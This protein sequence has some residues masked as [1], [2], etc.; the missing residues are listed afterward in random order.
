M[1]RLRRYFEACM[2]EQTMRDVTILV[3]L[4]RTSAGPAWWAESP[5]VPGLS[6]LEDELVKL[7]PQTKA[8]IAEL[9]AERGETLGHAR[10]YLVPADSR[11]AP[12]APSVTSTD[13]PLPAASPGRELVAA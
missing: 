3:H 1:N 4:E 10:A 7:L 12:V 9:L 8:A 13:L 2:E 6:V 11:T 5:E